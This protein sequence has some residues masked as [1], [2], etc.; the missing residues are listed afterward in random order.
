MV[1]SIEWPNSE[2]EKVSHFF[3]PKVKPQLVAQPD[4]QA[5]LAPQ[6]A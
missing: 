4:T 3:V 5:V 2:E 6:A 1:L